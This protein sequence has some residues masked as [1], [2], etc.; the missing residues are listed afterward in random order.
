MDTERFRKLQQSLDQE[1]ARL[2][3][4]RNEVDPAQIAELESTRGMLRFWKSQLRSMAWNTENE[5][6]SKIRLV[7]KPHRTALRIAGFEDQDASRVMGFPT[8]RRQLLDKLQVQVVV[9]YDRVEVKAIFPV[10]P[11][12]CQKC[13]PT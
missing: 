13:T 1:E 8:T 9:F 4:I 10:E 3:S 5:D 6:G 2:R 7:D 12:D 11:I